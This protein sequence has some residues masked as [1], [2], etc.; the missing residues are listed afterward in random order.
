MSKKA[1]MKMT[2][3]RTSPQR[4]ALLHLINFE[5]KYHMVEAKVFKDLKFCGKTQK[6]MEEFF[7]G[8]PQYIVFVSICNGIT[9]AIVRKGRGSSLEEAFE[10]AGEAATKYLE[11]NNKF[12]PIWIKIDIVTE[13]QKKSYDELR[14]ELSGSR[15]YFYRQGIAFDDEFKLAILESELNGRKIYDY[16]EKGLSL[17]Q[18]NQYL[19]NKGI[20]E[21]DS[22]PE[23][24]LTFRCKGYVHDEKW[25]ELYDEGYNYGRRI[26][27]EV[28]KPFVH[29]V[30]VK[31]ADF[32]LN[33]MGEDGKFIYGFYPIFDKDIKGYNIL[34]HASSLWGLV[35]CYKII[36][37]AEIK[38]KIKAGIDYLLKNI[39]F[40]D[41]NTTFLVDRE[42][43]E[44][45]IGGNGIAIIM[46]TEYMS[47]FQADEYNSVLETLGN[48]IIK[49]Q[50]DETGEFY[51]VLNANDFSGKAK[52]RT[53]YYDGEATFGLMRLYKQTGDKKWLDAA[54][55]SFDFLIK[56]DYAQYADHWLSYAVN[57]YVKNNWDEAIFKLGI[58][59]VNRNLKRIQ[60]RDT[61]YHTFLELLMAAF[62]MILHVRETKPDELKGIDMDISEFVGVIFHRLQHQLNGFTYPEMAMYFK[63]PA[64]SVNTF[65]VKHDAYRIR[66]DDV[67]HNIDGFYYFYRYYD[68]LIKYKK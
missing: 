39:V 4:E 16:Q 10:N 47:I 60:K 31:S 67:Q 18:L 13:I 68:E 59:N 35:L 52:D 63:S 6:N 57:E 9:R 64:R 62:E 38:E 33:Q 45:K 49:L 66:I 2:S 58:D 55:K 20:G 40:Y 24:L 32:L 34:R 15:E 7:G 51:H 36:G 19:A 25:H 1:P 43:N 17:K 23:Q 65:C 26:P 29:D 50:N 14:G 37:S 22:L 44:I 42:L 28:D 61:T 48:G 5:K 8:K 3:S 30:L 53:V 54:K 21:W 41:K 56:S 46:L 12:V 27:E 11:K